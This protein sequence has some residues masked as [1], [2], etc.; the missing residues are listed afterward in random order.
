MLFS[1]LIVVVLISVI[2]R[3]DVSSQLKGNTNLKDLRKIAILFAIAVL[4][5]LFVDTFIST[6]IPL[7][8]EERVE[9]GKRDGDYFN[10]VLGYEDLLREFPDSVDIHF[11]Y[12]DAFRRYG[13]SDCDGLIDKY[14]YKTES[15][16]KLSLQY[17]QISC[18]IFDSDFILR[19]SENLNQRHSA[20]ESYLLSRASLQFGNKVMAIS[21]LEDALTE[22]PYFP[23][24]ADELFELYLEFNR[25]KIDSLLQNKQIEKAIHPEI[26][27]AYF[28]TSGDFI[29]YGRILVLERVTNIS[30]LAFFAALVISIVWIFFLRSFDIF[31]PEP[32]VSI[33]L[34]F[35]LGAIWSFFCLPIYDYVSYFTTFAINGEFWNDFLY[36]FVVIGGSEELVKMMP[37]LLFLLLSK[38]FKEPYDYLLYASVSALG[39]AFAENWMYLEN[40]GNIVV[41]TI[42]AVVSHMV[43]ASII[44]YAFILA[45]FK[46]K[47][48]IWK[49]ATPIIGFVLAALAHGFY[50]FWLISPA[51]SDST[52]IT[53]LFFIGTLHLWFYFKNNAINNSGFYSVNKSF[54]PEFQINL[55]IFSFFIIWMIEFCFVSAK[56]GSLSGFYVIRNRALFIGAFLIY[57]TYMLDSIALQRGMWKKFKLKLPPILSDFLDLDRENETPINSEPFHFSGLK[58]RLF[59]SKSNQYIGNQ[60]P[61]SGTCLYPITVSNDTTW[62]VFK[63]NAPVRV[64]NYVSDEL[65]L[66]TKNGAQ[67]LTEDKVELICLFLPHKEILQQKNIQVSD[68]RYVGA[69]FSRI[70]NE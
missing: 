65:I 19:D 30:G 59:T 24:A 36:C 69:V 27:K 2:F 6:R 66:K 23:R 44:A 11:D 51:V 63:L 9:R 50:D 64:Q 1:I 20:Y 57:M 52:M 35:V 42:M 32:W 47:Q 18:G 54:N 29:N 16:S 60:L 38:R 45:H 43:D 25:G 56:Y 10:V 37:W 3:R 8:G 33:V 21:Y 46:F 62:Y 55:L 7:S 12:I 67:Q 22:K 17:A 41:R 5:I 15:Y 68:L 61:V 4:P 34:I 49:I 13:P 39:F 40:P 58:L 70:V 53:V 26:R 31:N 14:Q 48:K 28:Y